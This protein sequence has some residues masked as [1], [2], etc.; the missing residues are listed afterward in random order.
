M[1]L[2]THIIEI[3]ELKLRS[4]ELSGGGD[5]YGIAWGKSQLGTLWCGQ[6]RSQRLTD[7]TGQNGLFYREVWRYRN[8]HVHGHEDVTTHRCG[9]QDYS[10][11]QQV[12][13]GCL[14]HTLGQGAHHIGLLD[15][16]RGLTKYKNAGPVTLSP[17]LPRSPSIG[18]YCCKKALEYGYI[19]M[20]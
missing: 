13:K 12:P 7:S 2:K 3:S 4:N 5:A 6:L 20:Q 9:T 10:H 1:V 16:Y 17:R 18:V 15:Q 14:P 19:T 8:T 11:E